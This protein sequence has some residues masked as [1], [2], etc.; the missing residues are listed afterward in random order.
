MIFRFEELFKVE[1]MHRYFG[2]DS[3][4]S[5]IKATP[6][7]KTE[8]F[9]LNNQLLF[10]AVNAGFI[11]AYQTGLSDQQQ[12]KTA[13]LKTEA[14]LT[15]RL[16]LTDKNLYSYTGNLPD[17]IS[18]LIFHFW[19]YN[20]ADKSYRNSGQLQ[21]DEF[22]SEA[23]MNDITLL[24]QLKDLVSKKII[25]E[26]G[27][28][29]DN[30]LF[31]QMLN[32]ELIS[33]TFKDKAYSDNII[34]LEDFF[35]KPFGQISIRLNPDPVYNFGQKFILQFD[36]LSTY[37]QYILRSPHLQDL[38]DPAILDKLNQ[39]VFEMPAQ[40]TLPD[41]QKAVSIISK[42]SIPLTSTPQRNFRLVNDFNETNNSFKELNPPM[43]LPDP[44][45][46]MISNLAGNKDDSIKKKIFNNYF[47]M[48]I[49]VLYLSPLII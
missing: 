28:L 42:N 33:V 21:K 29:S 8:A 6:T 26:K 43:I 27:N 14:V 2:S 31:T 12:N 39:P 45:I 23:D 34:L 46:N 9:M 20:V 35:S 13:V 4:Y 24:G 10:K 48:P 1:F 47:I 5:G 18:N 30:A 7:A 25:A 17:S 37:R 3:L 15:F 32:Q 41:N 40:M 36:S 44:D 38:K 19:N 49:I 16:D 11:V 22:I